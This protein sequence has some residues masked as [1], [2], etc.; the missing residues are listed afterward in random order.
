MSRCV[1]RAFLCGED[2]YS[3][4]NYEHRR[5]WVRERLELLSGLF[6]VE[7]FSYAVMSNHLH[8]V[9]RVRPE[10]V[11]QW[12]ADEVAERWCRLFRGKAAIQAGKPYDELK[13][14]RIRKNPEQIGTCRERLKDL[15]WFMRCLSEP[16][17]R[18]ANRE[19]ECTGR[20]WEG[21]FKCQRLMDEGA[22]LACMAYVDLNPVR[23]KMAD[24]LEDSDFTSIYDRV[25]SR[26]A[27]ERLERL[28]EVK[29]PTQAQKR[30]ISRE[31]SRKN[32]GQWLVK[33][34]EEGSPFRG[35]DE[36]TYIT[37]LEWT[38]R[39]IRVDKPGYIPVKIERELDRYGLD[40]SEWAKNVA[41]YGSLFHRSPVGP[42]NCSATRE[43]E[44]KAG[45]AEEAA[46]RICIAAGRKRR[47]RGKLRLVLRFPGNQ[48]ERGSFRGPK[49]RLEAGDRLLVLATESLIEC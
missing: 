24:T 15:S 36:E 6:A 47:K 13:F 4:R 43:S 48:G 31:E 32:R 23:A 20:F 29:N 26:R 42:S 28:G 38:G 12:S 10:R 11:A 30:E 22:I 34:G 21:R 8:V 39:N 19:D 44:G 27:K 49:K 2:S 37:L 46:A 7:I 5:E 1:R 17:A 41:A 14:E 3:G 35:M 45:F 16:L 9:L 25:V 33:F 18:R 40:A